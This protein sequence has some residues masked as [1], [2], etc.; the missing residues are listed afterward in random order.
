V[1]RIVFPPPG[2]INLPAKPPTPQS[3]S[4]TQGESKY[5][6]P[7]RPSANETKKKRRPERNN[8]WDANGPPHSKYVLTL[9]IKYFYN[10]VIY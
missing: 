4:Q 1:P 6:A 7:D 8:L 10:K 9:I 2:V 5:G 3:K